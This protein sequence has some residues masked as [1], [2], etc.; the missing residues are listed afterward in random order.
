MLLTPKKKNKKIYTRLKPKKKT[1]T[2]AKKRFKNKGRGK[3]M[4]MF[5]SP[6]KTKK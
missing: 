1:K 2:T 5:L 3:K 6:K 4:I